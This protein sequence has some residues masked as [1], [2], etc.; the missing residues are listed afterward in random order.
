MW[1]K[2]VVGS[3]STPI[4]FSPVPSV[5]PSP[6]KPALSKFQ[7]DEMQDL[8]ENHSRVSEASWVNIINDN[9]L[10]RLVLYKSSPG[11]TSKYARKIPGLWPLNDSPVYR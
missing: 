5:L 10:M 6:Q 3:F 11:Y 7:F 8:P 4:C 9:E 2:F 1:D